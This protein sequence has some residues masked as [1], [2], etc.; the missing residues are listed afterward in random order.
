MRADYGLL[1]T[2]VVALVQYYD[3][4]VGDAAVVCS[5]TLVGLDLVLE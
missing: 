1:G 2:C 5:G 3:F 4:A